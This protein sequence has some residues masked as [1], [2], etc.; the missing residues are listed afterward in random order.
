LLERRSRSSIWD[1]FHPGFA[2]PAAKPSRLRATETD[3]NPTLSARDT[4]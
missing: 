3:G 2:R 1:S 4:G